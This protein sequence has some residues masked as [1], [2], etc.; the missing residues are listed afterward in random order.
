[1]EI[2]LGIIIGLGLAGLTPDPEPKVTTI[3]KERPLTDREC[4]LKKEL[5]KARA[6]IRRLT[7]VEK[8]KA[9]DQDLY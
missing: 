5:Q 9:V 3:L 1:M 4:Y 6:C 2:I 7:K 8:W